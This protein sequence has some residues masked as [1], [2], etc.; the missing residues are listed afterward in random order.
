MRGTKATIESGR[1]LGQY[2]PG[3]RILGQS[4]NAGAAANEPHN[5]ERAGL[6]VTW[7]G[8]DGRAERSPDRA[9]YV[10]NGAVVGS[11]RQGFEN[12]LARMRSLPKTS[13]VF[14]YPD[15]IVAQILMPAGGADAPK[16]ARRSSLPRNCQRLRGLEKGGPRAR[17]SGLP[18]SGATR[19][20][21][22]PQ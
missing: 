22:L 8:F 21:N 4:W 5:P 14:V 15:P 18:S 3:C 19:R 12:V 16:A 6:S 11:G 7:T 20:E 17:P 2:L 10:V 9:R 13:T 1:R